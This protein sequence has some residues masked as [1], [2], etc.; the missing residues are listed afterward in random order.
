MVIG[1]HEERDACRAIARR[2]MEPLAILGG[3]EG[4]ER[5]LNS[6]EVRFVSYEAG[7]VILSRKESRRVLVLLLSGRASARKHASGRDVIIRLFHEGDL[8]GIASLFG[9]EDTYVSEIRAEE[10]TVILTIPQAIMSDIF[11]RNPDAAL[12]YIEL[13]S[14]K[15]RYLNAKLDS[16]TAPSAYAKLCLYLLEN[17]DTDIPIQQLAQHLGISRMTLYRSLVTLEENR[18]ICKKGRV[19]TVLDRRALALEIDSEPVL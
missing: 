15:I 14:G 7:E 6:P 3:H 17:G 16:F 8:F 5:I 2:W 18:I 19:I 4:I 11:R 10:K 1:E 12:A 13:L 9:G